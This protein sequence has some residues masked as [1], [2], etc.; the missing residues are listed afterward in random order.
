[1]K[2]LLDTNPCVVY[3]RGKNALLRQRFALHPSSDINAELSRI[4]RLTLEDWELP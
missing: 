2:Y 1:M 3:L 4:P